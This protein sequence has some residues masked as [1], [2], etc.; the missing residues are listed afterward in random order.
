MSFFSSC[1]LTHFNR[2]H[3]GSFQYNFPFKMQKF[4]AFCLR[5]LALVLSIS[6]RTCRCSNM[7][8]MSIYHEDDRKYS[9]TCSSGH[10]SGFF[11]SVDNSATMCRL[12]KLQLECAMIFSSPWPLIKFVGLISKSYSSNLLSIFPFYPLELIGLE[13]PLLHWR[14]HEK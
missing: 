13:Y 5:N 6:C 2:T 14:E 10:S 3:P 7:K 1:L 8:M 12:S 4:V 9:T 11:S